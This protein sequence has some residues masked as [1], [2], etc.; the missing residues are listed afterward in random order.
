M[1]RGKGTSPFFISLSE[2][3]LCIAFAAM[4]VMG[5]QLH[6]EQEERARQIEG[7]RAAQNGTVSQPMIIVLGLSSIEIDGTPVASISDLRARAR[8]PVVIQVGDD[9]PAGRLK[10]ALETLPADAVISVATDSK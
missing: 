5:T 7:S 10:E 1:R 9:V 3:W 2:F 6:A 4:G 8:G